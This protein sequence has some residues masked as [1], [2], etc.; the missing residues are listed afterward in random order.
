MSNMAQRVGSRGPHS[1]RRSRVLNGALLLF[2]CKA[3]NCVAGQ[4]QQCCMTHTARLVP[5]I[6]PRKIQ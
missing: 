4:G 5:L 3:Q 6:H 2:T 1:T